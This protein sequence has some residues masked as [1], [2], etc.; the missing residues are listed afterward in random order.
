[1]TAK[2]FNIERTDD[3]VLIQLTVSNTRTVEKAARSLLH[4]IC[5]L[6]AHSGHPS[7]GRQCSLSGVKR[8]FANSP[9]HGRF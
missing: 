3:L 9:R 2:Y 7:V 4:R 5:P 6:V 1:M 8:T